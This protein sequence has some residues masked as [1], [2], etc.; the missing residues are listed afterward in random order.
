MKRMLTIFKFTIIKN[1]R[2][3]GSLLH[4][5]LMPIVLILIL[6]TA[7]NPMFQHNEISPTVVGYLNKDAGPLDGYFDQFIKSE[8]LRQVLNVAMMES[9]EE[10]HERLQAGEILA[11]IYLDEDFS[12]RVLAGEKTTIDIT[13]RPGNPLRLSIVENVLESFI[14]GAN[15]TEALNRMGAGG[16][17]YVHTVNVIED[18]PVAASGIMPGSMDYYAVTMLVLFIM[19]GALY[20]SSGMGESYLAAV[21]KRIKGTPIKAAEHYLGLVSANVITVF[22]QALIIFGFT[23]YFYGANWGMN[24]PVVFAIIITLVFVSVGLGTMIVMLTRSETLATSI[25]HVI[26][27]VFTFIAGGYIKI[28]FTGTVLPALQ[29]LSPNYLAQTAIFNTVYGGPDSQTTAMLGGLILIAV[30]TFTV[31]MLAER[32]AWN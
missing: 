9:N 29:H 32:R 23:R 18:L 6:G 8:D 11:L 17:N 4:M 25:L 27:P 3:T 19:Y 2:D 24:L 14:H 10:G 1:L 16:H 20:S 7:L 30:G 21:G 15:A 26:I 22:V 12:R 31:S 5:L 13:A 28:S